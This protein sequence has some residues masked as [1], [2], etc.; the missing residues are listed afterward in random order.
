M[1]KPRI[2]VMGV[3]M[4]GGAV[5]RYLKIK[6]F[7]LYFYDKYKNIGSLDEVNKADV[8][9]VCVPTP[10]QPETGF[11]FSYVE[12][13]FSRLKGK[14]I[15]ILK[16]TVLPG[17]TEKI[18]KIFNQHAILFNPEFLSELTA[19]RD[20]QQPDVQ[21]IGYTERSWEA[22]N[23]AV[24]ILPKAPFTKL[25]P[26]QEAELF[27]Y[28]HNVH[29]AVKVVFA[30]QMYDLCRALGAN[31][32]N[33]KECAAASKHILTDEYLR[34]GQGNYRGYGGTCFPKDIRA[35]IQFGEKIGVDLEL[36][37]TAEKINNELIKQQGIENHEKLGRE[38]L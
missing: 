4:V 22:A 12:D 18:Q 10:Y 23:I 29:G 25:V 32:N 7:E 16:S 15:V 24:K 19:D 8:V 21:I 2:G 11:D 5:S 13:A 6:D 36:L 17:T 30:N 38:N 37:K 9:F 31:Y 26:A 1:A 28:F 20:M 14:K 3:G 27:K 34:V 33:I 35:L